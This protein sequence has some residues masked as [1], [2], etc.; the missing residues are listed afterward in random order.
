MIAPA[1]EVDE[2]LIALGDDAHGPVR[3]TLTD[4]ETMALEVSLSAAPPRS[5]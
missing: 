5:R 1:S 4:A 3:R 2:M